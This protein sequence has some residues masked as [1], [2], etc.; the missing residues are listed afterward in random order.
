VAEHAGALGDLD[1][2]S[3]RLAKLDPESLLRQHVDIHAA[4]PPD[5][6][7]GLVQ[8]LAALIVED[9]LRMN[10]SLT[11]EVVHGILGYHPD[12]RL[13]DA[14]LPHLVAAAEDEGSGL[15][16]A[17]RAGLLHCAGTRSRRKGGAANFADARAFLTRGLALC[18]GDPDAPMLSRLHYDLG[19]VAMLQG[20]VEQARDGFRVSAE[21]ARSQGSPVAA[22]IADCVLAVFESRIG[23]ISPAECVEV[24]SGALGV[25]ED[26]AEVSVNA[27]R[28]VSNVR[29]HLLDEFC[30]TASEPEAR[31]QLARLT[32][33]PW[34]RRFSSDSERASWVAWVDL[35]FGDPAA[36]IEPFVRR[37]EPDLALDVPS[38]QRARWFLAWGDALARADRQEEARQAWSMGMA[39]PADAGN[40]MWRPELEERL[41]AT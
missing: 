17:T 41:A 40:W 11:P 26:L 16:N 2:M 33:D 9:S 4:A 6:L 23:A 15:T 36:A 32:D 38:E 34:V 3:A 24:L 39:C 13:Y 12:S 29:V 5:A 21:V 37:A 18:E 7:Q 14:V 35:A 22:A 20:E 1:R 8:S 19:Y 30:A 31:L 27:E 10:T 25:F 28:W